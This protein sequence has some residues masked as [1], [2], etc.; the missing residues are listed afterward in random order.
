[1][2]KILG[3]DLGKEFHPLMGF[4][5]VLRLFEAVCLWV[6]NLEELCYKKAFIKCLPLNILMSFHI[7]IFSWTCTDLDIPIARE[8][9]EKEEL[10]TFLKWRKLFFDVILRNFH[11]PEK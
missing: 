2:I 7:K 3:K 1:M 5:I 8:V 4:L 11:M 10:K 9:K 6:F